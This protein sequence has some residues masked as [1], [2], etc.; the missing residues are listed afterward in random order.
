M[1]PIEGIPRYLQIKLDIIED[2]KNKNYLPE[3]MIPPES[4]FKN[5]YKVSTITV[6]KAF[7]DLIKEGYLYA[8]QGKGT[9]VAKPQFTRELTMLSFTEE[10]K[11][12]GFN[13]ITKVHDVTLGENKLAATQLHLPEDH[14]LVQVGRIRYIDT[15]PIAYQKS[16]FD[17]ALL[18][19]R[20]LDELRHIESLYAYLENLGIKAGAAKEVYSVQK[21]NDPE[22]AI[23][24]KKSID[25]A[26]FFVQRLSFD[27]NQ[28]LFEYAE[29]YLDGSF[30]KV[31]VNLERK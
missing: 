23:L 27:Q 22:V 6:R 31:E 14:K 3:T 24:L 28:H 2:I 11:T 7:A 25:Y 10:M 4:Y 19:D 18:Q 20:D 30:Y 15:K 1:Y 29:S 16:Y 21:I 26:C 13:L 12:K 5:Y 17:A 8:I 9:Y